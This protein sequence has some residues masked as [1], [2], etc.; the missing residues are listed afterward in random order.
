M[1]P[2]KVVKDGVIGWKV[3]DKFFTGGLARVKAK[4]YAKQM[5]MEYDEMKH[6]QENFD[7]GIEGQQNDPFTGETT[8]YTGPAPEEM[9]NSPDTPAPAPIVRKE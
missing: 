1:T 8:D 4:R 6:G 7:N 2:I 9:E 3:D 5:Y